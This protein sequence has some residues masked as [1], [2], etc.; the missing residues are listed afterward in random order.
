MEPLIT[1][2][3]ANHLLGFISSSADAVQLDLVGVT[4]LLNYLLGL[5]GLNDWRGLVIFSDLS[6]SRGSFFLGFGLFFGILFTLS[7]APTG[8]A[9]L[10]F[11][12]G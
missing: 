12:F 10:A 3:T 9:P 7:L 11:G 8:I 2:V 6:G 1:F 4:S 5:D